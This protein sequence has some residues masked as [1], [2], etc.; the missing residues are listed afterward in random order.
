[1]KKLLLIL[2]CA[3][4]IVHCAL[5]Q[6]AIGSWKTHISYTN[7][8]QI[9]QSQDKIYGIS[10][11]ALFS[12]GKNDNI[13]ET[14]SKTY[15]LNDNNIHIIEYSNFNNLLFIAYN[16]SNIYLMTEYGDIVNISDIYIKNMIGSKQINHIY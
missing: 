6:S 2:N 12:V 9:T 7:I 10:T 1:M 8:S 4:C 3:L 15:G 14:Y 11:G 16:N 5:S 13:I